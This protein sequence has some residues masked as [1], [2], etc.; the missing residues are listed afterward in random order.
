MWTTLRDAA[1]GPMVVH[2]P[3]FINPATP[4]ED[5]HAFAIEILVEELARARALGALGIVTHFGDHRGSGAEAGRRQVIAAVR[6]ALAQSEG[7]TRLLLEN[8]A[9]E[10]GECG[11]R[12]EELAMVL[13]E[14]RADPRVGVC[15]DTAHSFASGYDWRTAAGTEALVGELLRLFGPERLACFHLNDSKT[16]IGSG[17]DLHANIGRGEIGA[18]CFRTLM[19]LPALA[20]VPGILE[21][22]DKDPGAREADLAALL[23]WSDAPASTG[24]EA[25][26]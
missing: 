5:K 1:C 26:R 16:V 23:T 10:G 21:T 14:L 22:P 11:T 19:T 18:D 17:R 25:G 4:E 20:E 3:Y 8:A 7:P 2:V 12:F 6:A 9:G 24:A 13:D 15:I